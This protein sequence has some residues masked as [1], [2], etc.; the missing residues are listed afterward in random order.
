MVGPDPAGPVPFRPLQRE[1]PGRTDLALARASRFVKA[2]QAFHFPALPMHAPRPVFL[3]PSLAPRIRCALR[4]STPLRLCFAFSVLKTPGEHVPRAARAT[5]AVHSKCS[6][7]IGN[8]RFRSLYKFTLEKKCPVA[9]WW[10]QAGSRRGRGGAAAALGGEACVFTSFI[11]VY[12]LRTGTALS[13]DNG[14]TLVTT[15]PIC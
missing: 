5:A 7:F 3:V 13:N 6:I 15:V 10:P 9:G 11:L 14:H 8:H 4:P 1:P 12:R 2:N